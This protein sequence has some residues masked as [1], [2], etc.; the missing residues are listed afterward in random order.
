MAGSYWQGVLK[1]RISR[2]RALAASATGALGAAFL[3][4]CGG[5]DDEGSKD[6]SGLLT[7]VEDTTKNA[8]PGGT[9]LSPLASD[10]LGLD[11][12]SVAIGSAQAPWAYSRLVLYKPARYPETPLGDVVGDGA[13]SW[14]MT[15][16]GLRFTFKLRPNVKLDPRP[17]TNG[18]MMN[19]QDV[20][21]SANK[22]K[23]GG[24]SRGEFF[25]SLS[26]NS[27]VESVEPPDARTVLV[28]MAF[29]K[30]NMLAN[31]AFQRYL[32]MMPVEADGRFDPRQEVRGSGPW[33]FERW[34]QGLGV[35]YVRNESWHLKPPF[36]E[37]L[38][39]PIVSEYAARRTQLIAGNVATTT[40][41]ADDLLPTKREQ[42]KLNLYAN[43]FPDDRPSMIGFSFL[44]GSPF[45]D[46]RVRRAASM[47]LD[48]ET[49]IDTFYNVSNFKKEGLPVESRWHTHFAAG[50]PPY[51][52]D[53]KGNGLGEG[54]KYFQY[55]VAEA[56][57]L[58]R[59]AGH[60]QALRM[61]GFFSTGLPLSTTR[62]IEVLAEMLQQGGL[63]S[64]QLSNLPATE[65]IN[66]VFNGGG[67]HEGL[68]MQ[69]GPGVSGD[70]DNQITVRFNVTANPP[71]CLLRTVFPWYQKT[72]SLIDA[73]RKELDEKKRL[74]I[75]EDLQ[76]EMALQMPAVPWPGIA[77]GFSLA[78]PW[79]ANFNI[80][81]AKS[82]ITAP[83]ESWPSYWFDASKK[84]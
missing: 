63:F 29:P 50:E 36:F 37:R 47:L 56:T 72:Q 70:I 21:F 38:E 5:A 62:Q 41:T 73:Q 57:K 82:V 55:D 39:H 51:W 64:I 30:A 67:L 11:P 48:R 15:P 59:A 83:S 78:W 20:V 46:E 7:K 79:F 65:F 43:S 61:P 25:N 16:D 69:Q 9:W 40:V 14:E 74:K 84:V 23:A 22:F 26:P 33:R 10:T 60:N 66:R 44:E 81:T 2:R 34:D 71:Q 53:P 75:L 8:K 3:A 49:F 35:K 18:R 24:V 45:R 1:G 27:P 77:S 19:A 28:K 6:S 17:P 58:V 52:I 42:P 68:A 4:A 76:K 31:F 12:Y 54:A 32:W 80:L 13:E